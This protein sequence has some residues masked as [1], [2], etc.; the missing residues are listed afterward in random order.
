MLLTM[1]VALLIG[2]T[3]IA[4]AATPPSLDLATVA[5]CPAE[6]GPGMTGPVPCVFDSGTPA[7]GYGTRWVL[8]SP[9]TCPKTTVQPHETVTCVSRPDWTGATGS[10]EGRTS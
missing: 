6:D 9:D 1:I 5:A 3:A 7:S 8:Y 4:C 10:G 2:V